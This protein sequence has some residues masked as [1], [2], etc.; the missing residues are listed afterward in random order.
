M[1]LT[2]YKGETDILNDE[3]LIKINDLRNKCPGLLK[4]FVFYENEILFLYLKKGNLLA[5]QKARIFKKHIMFT[6]K[7][8]HPDLRGKGIGGRMWQYVMKYMKINYPYCL[9][10]KLYI[11]KSNPYFKFLKAWH[12]RNGFSVEK[13][14]KKYISMIKILQ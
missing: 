5:M 2:I 4:K 7:C 10:F 3:L 14:K 9:Y 8:L 12:I 6:D 11:M 1:K 13:I